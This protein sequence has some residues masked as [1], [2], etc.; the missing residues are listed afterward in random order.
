MNACE[1][2]LNT[3]SFKGRCYR[4]VRITKPHTKAEVW[5][6]LDDGNYFKSLDDLVRFV[7]VR[8]IADA[9]C[10]KASLA[11]RLD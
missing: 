1:T 11:D 6:V 7:T 10:G 8:Q 2:T 3:G 9:I 5:W 4:H